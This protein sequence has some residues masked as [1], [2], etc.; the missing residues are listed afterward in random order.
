MLNFAPPSQ[1][2]LILFF[3]P[4]SSSSSSFLTLPRIPRRGASR[5]GGGHYMRARDRAGSR[6]LPPQKPAR[7][8]PRP[9]SHA[10]N[11][12]GSLGDVCVISYLLPRCPGDSGGLFLHDH[13]L[14]Q[15]K[16]IG[17]SRAPLSPYP[18]RPPKKGKREDRQRK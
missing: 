4:H 14:S 3:L 2:V 10:P 16:M 1:F 18:H 6:R 17:P 15:T 11:P 7:A 8:L 12:E 5:A 9:G 13:I